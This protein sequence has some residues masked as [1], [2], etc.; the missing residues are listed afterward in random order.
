M[1]DNRKPC[2]WIVV[3]CYNEQEVLPLTMHRIAQL[4][5]DMMD[6]E[7]IESSSRAIYIDDCSTDST[8]DLIKRASTDNHLNGGLRL[9]ENSGHQNVL[10]AGME[11]AVLTAGVDIVITIDADLQDDLAAVPQMVDLYCQGNDIVYGVRSDRTTDT[12]LKRNTARAFYRVMHW[13][14]APIIRDHA[15]CRLMSRRAIQR[16]SCYNGQHLFLRGIIPQLKFPQSSVYYSRLE[17]QAGQTKY[18]LWHMLRLAADGIISVY[19]GKFGDEP[20]KMV[21][22]HIV[23]KII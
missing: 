20:S 11:T 16:L 4:M 8:W 10:M 3:P 6:T 14:G 2:L 9:R 13:L 22:Y 21:R 17:R 7:K 19:T 23:E 12:F 18:T 15:D 5:S 1:E